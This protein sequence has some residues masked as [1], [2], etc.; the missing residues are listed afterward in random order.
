MQQDRS[1]PIAYRCGIKASRNP[2]VKDAKR[3]NRPPGRAAR[4]G[5]FH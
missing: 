1:R 2:G 5:D 4:M 3:D